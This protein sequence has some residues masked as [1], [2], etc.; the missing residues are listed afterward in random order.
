MSALCNRARG[1][2]VIVVD[3]APRKL[4]LTLGA[5][6]ELET[7]FDAVSLAELAERLGY[8][9]AGDLLIVLA[10]LLR[11]GGEA[12]TPAALADARLDVRE[13]ARAVTET[14]ERALGDD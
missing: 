3:G 1:E 4:C 2:T 11:G 9:S 8:L 13:A 7:A 14:F 12:I 10:A 6:A 5:L